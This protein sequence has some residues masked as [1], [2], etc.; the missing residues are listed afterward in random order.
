LKSQ[1]EPFRRLFWWLLVGSKGGRTRLQILGALRLSSANANQLAMMLGL[2]YKTIQHH[3]RV[4]VENRMV[5][6]TGEKYNVTYMLSPELLA[7]I[8]ILE[9]VVKESGISKKEISRWAWR[10]SG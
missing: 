4:L 9:S 5:S 8:D 2:N 3:L 10:R 7:N 6:V 1:Y